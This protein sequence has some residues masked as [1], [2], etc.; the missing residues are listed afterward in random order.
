MGFEAAR[1]IEGI[2]RGYWGLTAVRCA[3]IMRLAEVEV[4]VR[5]RRKTVVVVCLLCAFG[6]SAGGA[7]YGGEVYMQK[8]PLYRT[9]RC[10][11]CHKSSQ[12]VSGQDLN[13]FGVDFRSNAYLWNAALAAK[14]SDE[15]GFRNGLEL[16]DENGD[17]V[18]EIAV[19]RSNPG[20]PFNTPNSVDRSTW[21]ILKSLFED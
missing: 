8:L 21:G 2:S 14:D 17:G 1:N 12:P 15:D 10:A 6:L 19:E 16:G 13:V 5:S 4:Q 3:D 9:Y 11:I 7:V 20:D 18:P